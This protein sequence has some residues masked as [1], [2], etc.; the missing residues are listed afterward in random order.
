MQT[1]L[2]TALLL[3][4]TIAT[5][6]SGFQSAAEWVKYNPDDGRSSVLLPQQPKVRSERGTSKAGENLTKHIA[7]AEDA[8]GSF[9]VFGF[10]DY[11]NTLDS[12]K[13]LDGARDGSIQAMKGSLLRESSITLDGNGGREYLAS[14]NVQGIE[15]LVLARSYVVANRIYMLM[16]TYRKSLD[17]ETAVKNAAKFFNSF[18]LSSSK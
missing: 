5:L 14:I 18:K 9:Y 13:S 16:Y 11:S 3:V 12:E 7:H 17:P 1:K 10:T 8:L 6:V 2:I 4:L 15:V